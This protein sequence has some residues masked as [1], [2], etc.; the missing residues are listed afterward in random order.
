MER[1][2]ARFSTALAILSALGLAGA[3]SLSSTRAEAQEVVPPPEYIATAQPVYYEGHAS[4]WYGGRWYY[5]NG[6]G[7][8]HYAGEPAYLRGWRGRPGWGA[9]YHY[10]N[11]YRG[12]AF[13]WGRR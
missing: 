10:G 2:L 6:G 5:R 8:G 7:W 9:R 4:Y 12:G 3:I 1:R 13:H 11:G